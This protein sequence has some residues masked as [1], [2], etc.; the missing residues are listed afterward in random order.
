[1]AA[2]L[3]ELARG[4][5]AFARDLGTDLDRVTLV[6]WS[7]FGR[8]VAENASAGLDH[9]HGGAMLVL[10]GH[11]AGGQVI[12]SW[13]TLAPASLDHGD[14]AITID[15]RD[16]LSEILGERMACT[17]LGTVFPGWVATPRG[18]TA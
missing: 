5:S 9:G 3:D 2:K 1:M 15:Y 8:R 16:I 6:A 11:V 10:G 7:E 17:S 14:L 18:V 4:L 12:S 13:P